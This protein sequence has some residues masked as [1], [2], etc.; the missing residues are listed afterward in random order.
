MR[1]PNKDPTLPRKNPTKIQ[2]FQEKTQL[3]SNKKTQSLLGVGLS[4]KPYKKP[5]ILLG[6]L[7]FSWVFFV[8]LPT[9]GHELAAIINL[10]ILHVES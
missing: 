2:H 5:N 3:K 9:P 1:K 8:G 4:E 10:E 7:D 6:L